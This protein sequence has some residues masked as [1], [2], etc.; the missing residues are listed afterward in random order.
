MKPPV[1]ENAM[2]RL[3]I[4]EGEWELELIHPDFQSILGHTSFTWMDGNQFMIQSANVNQSEFPSSM[5]VY[6]YDSNTDTYIQHYFDSR[7]V[8]RLYKMSIK[9]RNWELWRNSSDFSTLDLSQRFWGEF[10]A[11]YDTIQSTWEKSFDGE[12]WE[13]DFKIIYRKLK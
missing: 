10:N 11:S 9:Q 4:F 1:R 7:G 13:H 6:D 2:N 3:D 8:A 5:I 12:K